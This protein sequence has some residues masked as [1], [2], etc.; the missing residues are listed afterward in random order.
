MAAKAEG[1]AVARQG[2][3]RKLKTM[4]KKYFVLREET[5][6]LQHSARLEYY[7]S[8]RKFRSG[9]APRHTRILPLT[10]CYK[11][12]RRLDL[13]QKHVIAFFTKEEQFCVV[14]E[15]EE[16]MRNWF[17][18]ILKLYRSDQFSREL[19]HPIRKCLVTM[20]NAIYLE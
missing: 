17:T 11:I 4:K 18:S 5:A 6:D 3:L 14:A 9:T 8:E 1:G 13:K 7:E 16:D 10:N 2:Y 19:Q 15:D 12:I 20:F